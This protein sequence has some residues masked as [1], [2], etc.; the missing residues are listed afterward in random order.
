MVGLD[1]ALIL[2]SIVA[3]VAHVVVGHRLEFLVVSELG[4]MIKEGVGT[5]GKASG[6]AFGSL[7]GDS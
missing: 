6:V 5:L 4:G 2:L 3:E 7:L 1:G